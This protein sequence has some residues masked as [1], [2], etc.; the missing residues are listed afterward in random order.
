MR[1]R[2][3]HPGYFD[4]GSG[5]L[6]GKIRIRDPEGI[7]IRIRNKGNCS[8]SCIWIDN[9]INRV[10]T[11]TCLVL[12]YTVP[13]VICATN[14]RIGNHVDLLQSCPIMAEQ[15][16]ICQYLSSNKAENKRVQQLLIS[17]NLWVVCASYAFPVALRKFLFAVPHFLCE[18]PEN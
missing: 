16:T 6:D 1:I 11:F 18:L 17:I 4:P 15:C 10:P 12:S 3:Q 5:I 7:N 8:L 14:I 2:I 9:L 13:V